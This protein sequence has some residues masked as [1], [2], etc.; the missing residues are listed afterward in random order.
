[1]KNTTYLVFALFSLNI[2]LFNCREQKTPDEKVEQALDEFDEELE[3]ASDEIKDA[4]EDLKDN[5]KEV[6][7]DDSTNGI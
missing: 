1:M 7:E 6:K 5:I 3:D 2:L 4:A